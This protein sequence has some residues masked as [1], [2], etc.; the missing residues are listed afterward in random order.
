MRLFKWLSI[1]C[2]LLFTAAALAADAP[3]LSTYFPPPEDQ[4]GWRTLL[5]ESGQPSA[6]QKAKRGNQNLSVSHV[7]SLHP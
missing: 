3:S 4:G 2:L 6:E 7:C 5:P 1:A